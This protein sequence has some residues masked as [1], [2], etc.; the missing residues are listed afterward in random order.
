MK[1]ERER[2]R[3]RGTSFTGKCRNDE[4]VP[5]SIVPDW[6]LF[7]ECVDSRNACNHSSGSRLACHR[8]TADST[9]S[10]IIARIRFVV[11]LHERA[12]TI[13]AAS[14]LIS[15]LCW[16]QLIDHRRNK[17]ESRWNEPT[18]QREPK[19]RGAQPSV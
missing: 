16:K 2:E 3:E 11:H 18:T 13:H 1:K 10:A 17:G 15:L 5:V 8:S 4:I 9:P 14:M 7:H 6:I 19:Q 12:S